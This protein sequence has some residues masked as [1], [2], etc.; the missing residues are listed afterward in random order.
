MSE[1]CRA[2]REDIGAYVLN[3]LDPERRSA[4][5]AHL[6]GCAAC[7]AEL[8]E[9]QAVARALPAADPL[10]TDRPQPPPY[11]VGAALAAAAAIGVALMVGPGLLQEDRP[12]QWVNAFER[13]P[14]GSSAT[15]FLEYFP[16]GTRVDLTAQGLP[17][18]QL[19]SLW[20]ETD[21]G[22][23]IPGGTFWVPESG[24]VE[25]TLTAAIDLKKCAALG[26]SNADGDTVMWSPINWDEESA[27]PSS[28]IGLR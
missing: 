11:Q 3:S 22:E 6:D 28:A 20:M 10:R 24:D 23:R 4:L 26:V 27:A 9:L 19:Y 21:D 2:Y 25:V 15:A 8:H 14:A 12:T 7:R 17:S 5:G 1:E 13:S 18:K 16:S